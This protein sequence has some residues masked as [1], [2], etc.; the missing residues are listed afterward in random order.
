MCAICLQGPAGPNGPP[1][2]D[3]SNGMPG[4]IGPPGH[5][6]PPGYVGP[7]VSKYTFEYS[8]DIFQFMFPETTKSEQ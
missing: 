4:A 1:G 8:F 7:A 6:G 5:R 3:G 2:K